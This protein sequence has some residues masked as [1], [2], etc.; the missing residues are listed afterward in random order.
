MPAVLNLLATAGTLV[1]FLFFLGAFGLLA[2][3]GGILT[4]AVVGYMSQGG[5]E[6]NTTLM[7]IGAVFCTVPASGIY[8]MPSLHCV[9]LGGRTTI[10]LLATIAWAV[11]VLFFA[12]AAIEGRWSTHR[13]RAS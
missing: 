10:S 3:V 4:G 5:W 12:L 2:L 7:T 6:T 1:E 11:P 13:A 9:A 8:W